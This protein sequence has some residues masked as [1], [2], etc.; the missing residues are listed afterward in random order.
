MTEAIPTTADYN[1]A[2]T[3]GISLLTLAD[4]QPDARSWADRNAC[5]AIN[6]VV[7]C[8]HG[9]YMMPMCP[10]YRCDRS[11]ILDHATWWYDL[12]DHTVFLLA[13]NYDHDERTEVDARLLADAHGL[14]VE[15]RRCDGWYGHGAT[16]LRFY[17]DPH[18]VPF[19]L[20]RAMI[21]AAS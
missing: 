15:T 13:H 1:F 19:P 17:P 9:A 14:S 7:R 4:L 20:E 11:R 12:Y 18:G 3:G 5:R 8:P 16:P 10:G 2:T 21:E 6:G